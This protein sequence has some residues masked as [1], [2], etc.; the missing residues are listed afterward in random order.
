MARRTAREKQLEREE[1]YTGAASNLVWLAIQQLDH[2]RT[3]RATKIIEV[4][5]KVHRALGGEHA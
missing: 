2:V 4:L 1:E 5:E 3:E